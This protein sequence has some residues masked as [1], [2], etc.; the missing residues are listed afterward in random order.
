MTLGI[1]FNEVQHY[2]RAEVVLTDLPGDVP[3][4][5]RQTRRG[6]GGAQPGQCPARPG[7]T[8]RGPYYVRVRAPSLRETGRSPRARPDLGKPNTASGTDGQT[9]ST[10]TATP[11]SP[12]TTR[13][14][15]T[16]PP[17][18]TS[19]SATPSLR[20]IKPPRRG[21]RSR[22]LLSCTPR[23]TIAEISRE[24]S[25][26]AAALERVPTPPRPDTSAPA[27]PGCA[28]AR[29]RRRCTSANRDTVDHG[30]RPPSSLLSRRLTP[31]V[32]TSALSYL[33]ARDPQLR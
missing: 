20:Q 28:C 16:M 29:S 25:A 17:E 6:R 21:P 32:R 24:S 7:H 15:S 27:V 8:R 23:W 12:S 9:P 4:P 30:T 22:S 14:T 13:A 33:R 18:R 26:K 2:P 3:R 10:P 1:L 11:P 31:T 5:R 19:T